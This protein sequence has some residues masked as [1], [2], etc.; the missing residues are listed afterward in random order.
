MGFSAFIYKTTK[1]QSR[2]SI[3]DSASLEDVGALEV[4]VDV[5]QTI[6]DVLIVGAAD[7]FLLALG[8][9]SDDGER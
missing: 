6:V 7:G 5:D 4:N 3:L 8:D 9:T 2:F 1:F